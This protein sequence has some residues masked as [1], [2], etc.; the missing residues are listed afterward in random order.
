MPKMPSPEEQAEI[1]KAR[2]ASDAELIKGGAEFKSKKR[3]DKYG[4]LDL[5]PNPTLVDLNPTE[6]QRVDIKEEMENSLKKSKQDIPPEQEN[7]TE[8]NTEKEITDIERENKWKESI[9]NEKKLI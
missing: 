7:L 6:E 5:D 1:N 2:A 4:L 8:E 9:E 3:S